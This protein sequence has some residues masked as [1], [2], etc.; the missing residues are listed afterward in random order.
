MTLD[1]QVDPL[2]RLSKAAT[3]MGQESI[4]GA[5]VGPDVGALIEL[6]NSLREPVRAH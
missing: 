2:V 1:E 3:G 5:V 6:D 4:C